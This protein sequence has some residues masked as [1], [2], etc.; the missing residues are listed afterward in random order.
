MMHTKNNGFSLLELAIVMTAIGLM[1][2]GIIVA[3][4]MIRSAKVNAVISDISRY[5]GAFTDFRD[6]YQALPGD[7][8]TAENFWGSDT[9]CPATVYTA[10]PHIVTCNGDG[11]G[12]IDG[13][14]E[15]FRAWQQMSNA[16]FIS[17]TYTGV[18][19]TGGALHHVLARNAPVA[20]LDG[21]GFDLFWLGNKSGDA[22]FYDAYYPVRL[23]IGGPTAT[24]YFY[25]PLFTPTEALSIDRKVDDG[26]PGTGNIMPY[27]SPITPGCTSTDVSDTAAYVTAS[28]GI[29]CSLN[30]I[31]QDPVK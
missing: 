26:A 25:A 18:S 13:T 12:H 9:T 20:V 27:K 29:L 11:N 24:S 3:Q 31:I 17:G 19:G 4:T 2:G 8:P 5:T 30:V 6:K 10:T 7:M 16:G 28:S 22:N 1:M 15:P 14:T 23:G 21:G